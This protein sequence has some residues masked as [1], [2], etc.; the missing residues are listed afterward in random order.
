MP[1]DAVQAPP[2]PWKFR[3][4]GAWLQDPLKKRAAKVRHQP[5]GGKFV[6]SCYQNLTHLAKSVETPHFEDAIR[7]AQEWFAG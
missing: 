2:F 7:V 4:G 1:A 6:V 5:A 3:E